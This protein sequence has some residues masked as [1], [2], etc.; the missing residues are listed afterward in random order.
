MKKVL[1]ASFP[2][3][4]N[5]WLSF[6]LANYFSGSEIN[7][8]NLKSVMSGSKSNSLADEGFEFIKHHAA[9]SPK[10]LFSA[11]FYV[12]LVRDPYSALRSYRNFV[13][14]QNPWLFK[15]DASFLSCYDR[16]FGTW[17][18]NVKSWDSAPN[19]LFVRYEDLLLDTEGELARILVYLGNNV[20]FTRLK[21]SVS[22]SSVERMRALPGQAEFMRSYDGEAKFVR[23]NKINMDSMAIERHLLSDASAVEMINKYY[24]G[25]LE[26]SSPSFS[27]S[28]ERMF[29]RGHFPFRRFLNRFL[30]IIS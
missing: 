9:A 10:D 12:Y 8:E 15:S 24:G 27:H 11:D 29:F 30:K 23:D 2:K 19:R 20:D 3:S 26:F 22:G 18:E 17:G 7:F 25:A 4:G 6:L 1:L 28:V 13:Q 21:R 14:R 5:T 16:W